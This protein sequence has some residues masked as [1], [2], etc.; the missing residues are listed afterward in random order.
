MKKYSVSQY[1]ENISFLN[2]HQNAVHLP[3]VSYTWQPAYDMIFKILRENVQLMKQSPISG[4]KNVKGLM[5]L[6]RIKM[7]TMPELDLFTCFRP[8]AETSQT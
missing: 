7:C 8:T 3:V 1:Q 4:E 6:Q 5:P 2:P